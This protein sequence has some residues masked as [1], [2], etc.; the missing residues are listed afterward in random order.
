[1]TA[2]FEG[3]LRITVPAPA[4]G[5]RFD[6]KEHGLS[7]CM[8]AVDFVVEQADSYLFIEIKDPAR[9]PHP[10]AS[11]EQFSQ[12]FISGQIDGDLTHKFRDSFLYEWAAGRA[13]KPVDYLVLIALGTLDTADLIARRDALEKKLPI[14]FPANVPWKRSLARLCGVF[15]I[16]SW[17][18]AYPQ[19]RVER[20]SEPHPKARQED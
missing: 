16:A 10:E 4:I 9:G 17:N 8:K 1:M 6:G 7:H 5:R 15:N 19:Y 13:D 20:V 12:R 3:D 14:G 2:L 18:R 11:A